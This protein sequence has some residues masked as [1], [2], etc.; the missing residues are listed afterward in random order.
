VARPKDF[1]A[2]CI[3]KVKDDRIRLPDNEKRQLHK[4]IIRPEEPEATDSV[5]LD[6]MP[7]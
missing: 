1:L 4:G 7:F 5:D 6:N 2:G 3:Y